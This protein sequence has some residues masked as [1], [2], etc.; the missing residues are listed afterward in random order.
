MGIS[1]VLSY[2]TAFDFRSWRVPPPSIETESANSLSVAHKQ[3]FFSY[4]C[5]GP[6]SESKT[7]LSDHGDF[8]LVFPGRSKPTPG[9]FQP[10]TALSEI[11]RS[12]MT[13]QPQATLTI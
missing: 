2:G 5:L 3:N 10:M 6:V 4:K 12:S 1:R 13:P 9:L 7:S 8:R 11:P